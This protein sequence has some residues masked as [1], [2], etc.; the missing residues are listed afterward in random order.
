MNGFHVEGMTEDKFDAFLAAE[1][2]KPV[3]GEHAFHADHQVVAERRYR[4][5]KGFRRAGDVAM[6]K[7]IALRIQNAEKHLSGMKVD[8]AVMFL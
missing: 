5:E 4:P 8:S 7:H 1:I 3:P 2:G 6:Q